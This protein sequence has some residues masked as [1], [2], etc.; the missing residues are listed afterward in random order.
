MSN[1]IA[2]PV[3]S[4]VCLPV[5]SDTASSGPAQGVAGVTPQGGTQ[6]MPAAPTIHHMLADAVSKGNTE[7]ANRLMDL[8]ERAESR[9]ARREY[10]TAFAA[11]RAE[12]G[13]VEKTGKANYGAYATLDD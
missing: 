4:M 10:D 3:P 13:V 8:I 5:E 11:A 6:G 2:K 9:A 12:I 7:L 1:D